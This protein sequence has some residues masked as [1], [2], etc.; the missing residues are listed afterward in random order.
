VGRDG[1]HEEPRPAARRPIAAKFFGGVL[2]QP[3]IEALLSDEHLSVDG[4]LIEA[5]ASMNSFKPKDGA[6]DE[7][8]ARA[9]GGIPR[10]LP[11]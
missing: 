5:F 3:R 4:T 7:P 1:V 6:G 8:P 2:S 9:R 11:R 10:R